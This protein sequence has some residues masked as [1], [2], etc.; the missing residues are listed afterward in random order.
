MGLRLKQ[1]HI[2]SLS[3][4]ESRHQRQELLRVRLKALE[5]R[6][7]RLVTF[8]DRAVEAIMS[9]CF[10]GRL[11]YALGRIVLR[12]VGRQAMKLHPVLVLRQPRFSGIVEPVARPVIDDQKDLSRAIGS[13]QIHQE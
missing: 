6:Y 12:R 11:P 4:L 3:T 2:E 1:L 13:H 7:E 9:G 5:G 8:L 10:P